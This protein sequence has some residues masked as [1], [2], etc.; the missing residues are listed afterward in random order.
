MLGHRL[1]VHPFAA[2]PDAAVGEDLRGDEVLDAGPRQLHPPDVRPAGE[3]F[4]QALHVEGMGP[5]EGLGVLGRDDLR[6]GRPHVLDRPAPGRLGS[7]G[8]ARWRHG[9]WG[10]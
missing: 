9:E 4:S 3:D 10:S 1:G 5:D 7:D 8:D 2:R 6:T